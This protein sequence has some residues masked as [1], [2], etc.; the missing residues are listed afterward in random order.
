MRIFLAVFPPSETRSWAHEAA[1]RL[2]DAGEASGIAA[3]HVA[4]V[5]RENLHYT[6]SFL[7]ELNEEGVARACAAAAAAVSGRAAFEATLGPLGA[8]PSARRARVLWVG[9]AHG[10]APF[11]AL[12]GRVEEALV[13]S[14]FDREARPFTPHLTV[15]RVR[16]PRHDWTAA[17]SRAS[18]Q[19]ADAGATFEARAVN[20]VR[21]TL[22]PGGSQYETVAEAALAGGSAPK[23]G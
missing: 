11:I 7:G 22:A 8:F 13:Q 15:G 2:R 20:V 23:N 6:L 16:E 4:W 21:S 5:K 1:G 18:R 17:L 3:S 10:E 14:G 19:G 9:L 12:A